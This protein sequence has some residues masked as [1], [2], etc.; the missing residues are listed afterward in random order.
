MKSFMIRAFR[1]A[2]AGTVRRRCSGIAPNRARRPIAPAWRAEHSGLVNRLHA[3]LARGGGAFLPPKSKVGMLPTPAQWQPGRRA[4]TARHWRAVGRRAHRLVAGC[5]ALV[6]RRTSRERSAAAA[7]RM[8][9]AAGRP[10]LRRCITCGLAKPENSG[11]L[12]ETP[13]L[14]AFVVRRCPASSA[15]R[16]SEMSAGARPSWH[17]PMPGRRRNQPQRRRDPV[18]VKRLGTSASDAAIE[19]PAASPAQQAQPQAAG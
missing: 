11:M 7:G 13:M 10:G 17:P 6:G 8:G 16:Q 19:I 5:Q 18:S 2:S 15:S 9:N 1:R 12:T 3:L 4:P 14:D